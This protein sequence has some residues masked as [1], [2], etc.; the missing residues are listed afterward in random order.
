[1]FEKGVV[2]VGGGHGGSQL[3][4]SLRA[5]GYDGRLTV[6]GVAIP[7][8]DMDGAIPVTSREYDPKLGPRPNNRNEVLFTPGKGKVIETYGTGDVTLTLRYWNIARGQRSARTLSW[9]FTV[10]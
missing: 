7:E 1:M 4:A 3:A 9:H 5:G 6:N 2:I 8:T 10:N